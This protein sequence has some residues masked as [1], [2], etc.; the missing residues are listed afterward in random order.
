MAGEPLYDFDAARQNGF[1]DGCGRLSPVQVDRLQRY[2]STIRSFL[3]GLNP[4]EPT[5]LRKLP[6]LLCHTR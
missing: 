4:F 1:V 3:L 6:A 2:E 5:D